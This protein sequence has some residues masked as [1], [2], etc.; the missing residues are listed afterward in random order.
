M[1]EYAVPESF[2]N[3]NMIDRD[4]NNTPAFILLQVAYTHFYDGLMRER[5]IGVEQVHM[6]IEGMF[7]VGEQNLEPAMIVHRFQRGLEYV[8]GMK[9]DNQTREAIS[10][11]SIEDFES[12]VLLAVSNI[13]EGLL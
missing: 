10:P 9:R 13:V 4:G 7:D 12:D 6:V 3:L 1:K 8:R 2:A 11:A 5:D